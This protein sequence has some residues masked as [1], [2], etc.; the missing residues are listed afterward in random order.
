MELRNAG[1]G[2]P[3]GGDAFKT[4]TELGQSPLRC[5]GCQLSSREARLLTMDSLNTDHNVEPF[6]AAPRV[7]RRVE[8]GE[9][10][11]AIAELQMHT[12]SSA[13]FV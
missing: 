6:L 2:R 4:G 10:Y 12:L 13:M 8:A 1:P 11:G 7:T 9:S 5:Q 3:P